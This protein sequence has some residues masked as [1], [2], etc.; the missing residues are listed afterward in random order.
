[1]GNMTGIKMK[2]KDGAGAFGGPGEG[3]IRY[4]FFGG[5]ETRRVAVEEGGRGVASTLQSGKEKEGEKECS[6]KLAAATLLIDVE[7]GNWSEKKRP[8]WRRLTLRKK[9]GKSILERKGRILK[10]SRS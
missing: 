3:H 9:G 4:C 10:D 7:G 1:V 8:T 5:D 6:Q 2:K